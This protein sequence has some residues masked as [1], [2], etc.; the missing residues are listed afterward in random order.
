MR[1][2]SVRKRELSAAGTPSVP[3]GTASSE[4]T[5]WRASRSATLPATTHALRAIQTHLAQ[6]LG[7]VAASVVDVVGC[8]GMQA[9]QLVSGQLAH[10]ARGTA[11]HEG[12]RRNLG[13][14]RDQGA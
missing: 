12:A 6:A 10:P 1:S 14:R 5:A 13:P 4:A 8:R 3:G 2:T 7:A 9:L 11:E